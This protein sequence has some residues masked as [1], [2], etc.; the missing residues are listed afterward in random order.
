[1]MRAWIR[2]YVAVVVA[3]VSILFFT[4]KIYSVIHVQLSDN[5]VIREA[6]DAVIKQNFDSLKIKFQGNVYIRFI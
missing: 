1:M 4:L 2:R 5:N 6:V 3:A